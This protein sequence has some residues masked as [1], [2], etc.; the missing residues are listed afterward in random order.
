MHE[1]LEAG[2]ATLDAAVPAAARLAGLSARLAAEDDRGAEA[3]ERLK[4]L[5]ALET[6]LLGAGGD[7][8]AAD[9]A[10]VRLTDLAE[11]LGDA[12]G[13]VGRLQRFVV[14]IM[15]LEPAVSRAVRALE[16]VVEFTRAGRQVDSREGQVRGDAEPA[17]AGSEGDRAVTEVARIPAE[18]GR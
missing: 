18:E 15:L 5:I 7:L 6:G 8:A 4:S 13:T 1:Q 16:P 12:G 14:D 17:D 2:L 9:A 3:G 11:S 10:L